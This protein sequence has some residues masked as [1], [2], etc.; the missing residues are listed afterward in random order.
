MLKFPQPRPALGFAA[1]IALLVLGAAS[2]AAAGSEK[3]LYIA[4]GD[5]ARPPVGWVEF[6]A[7]NPA[8]C[9]GENRPARDVVLSQQAWDKLVRIN[10]WVN[11]TIQPNSRRNHHR[12]LRPLNLPFGPLIG[13]KGAS[14]QK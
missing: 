10:R 7:E 2:A 5:S 12:R 1:A 11:E 14:C 3:L 13:S 4:I 6:C 9:L 8:D